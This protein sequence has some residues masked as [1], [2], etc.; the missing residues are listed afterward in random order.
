MNEID[1]AIEEFCQ[2]NGMTRE[3]LESPAGDIEITNPI[4]SLPEGLRVGGTLTL[5]AQSL[6]SVPDTIVVNNLHIIGEDADI[7]YPSFHVQNDVTLW[8]CNIV[9]TPQEMVVHGNLVMNGVQAQVEP[10]QL[11]VEGML[12]VE[13]LKTPDVPLVSTTTKV[14]NLYI[15]GNHQQMELNYPP[16]AVSGSAVV[17]GCRIL[18]YPEDVI[19]GRA[20]DLDNCNSVATPERVVVPR[21]YTTGFL[22]EG[23]LANH[24]EVGGTLSA[25]RS[26]LE[27]LPSHLKF[28]QLNIDGTP[29]MQNHPIDFQIFL[30]SQDINSERAKSMSKSVSEAYQ[31][32]GMRTVYKD[33]VTQLFFSQKSETPAALICCIDA[34]HPLRAD[35][36]RRFYDNF[37][38]LAQSTHCY[39]YRLINTN[40]FEPGC[41]VFR[42]YNLS[43]N[44]PEYLEQIKSKDY[45]YLFAH[46]EK[47]L[48]NIRT[49]LQKVSGRKVAAIQATGT[50][51]S[52]LIASCI[53]DAA[54]KKQLLVAPRTNIFDEVRQFLPSNVRLDCVTY[55]Y[56]S[57]QT[58]EQLKAMQFDRIYF[59][60][61]HH[62]GA[63]RWGEKAQQLLEANPNAQV[64]G[65]TATSEHTHSKKG[66]R[67]IG[68]QL[69]DAV[70]GRLNLPTALVNHTL[71]LPKYVCMPTS[72]EEVRNDLLARPEIKSH[73]DRKEQTLQMLADVEREHPLHEVIRQNL[74]NPNAK[75]IVFC[76]DIASIKQCK[77]ELTNLLK[78]AGLSAKSY[79]Y[80]TGKGSDESVLEKFKKETSKKGPQLIFCVDKLNEGVHVPGV[81]ALFFM[82]PTDSNIVFHQQLGRAMAAGRLQDTVVFD[83]VNN[84]YSNRVEDLGKGVQTAIAVKEEALSKTGAIYVEQ[85]GVQFKEDNILSDIYQR[86][87]SYA[88]TMN[89]EQLFYKHFDN[90]VERYADELNHISIPPTTQKAE[91]EIEWLS[92]WITRK[93]EG[94]VTKGQLDRLNA[95]TYDRTILNGLDH[96]RILK[97]AVKDYRMH[98]GLMSELTEVSRCQ[99]LKRV[100]QAIKGTLPLKDF[101]VMVA[102]AVTFHEAPGKLPE[103][104]QVARKYGIFDENQIIAKMMEL[105]E[106]SARPQKVE[107]TV[108]AKRG[109]PTLSAEQ[110]QENA[111]KRQVAK[112]EDGQSYKINGIHHEKTRVTSSEEFA[113]IKALA[114]SGLAGAVA[115]LDN[116]KKQNTSR[117]TSSSYKI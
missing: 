71:P 44:G 75:C 22:S 105:H 40:G 90:I 52:L 48:D 103:S 89:R 59:D 12:Y 62:M 58:P 106:Q 28:N 38:K 98:G 18:S 21:D 57:S 61:F 55:Q 14:N 37:E 10:N 83:M 3:Q 92:N 73:P 20:L 116:T 9:S 42:D 47:M 65:T 82:R 46:N 70:A 77:K 104:Y 16:C 25:F 115:A 41:D 99:I 107:Q 56:L 108:K 50:G 39:Q 27:V 67:D 79:I 63:D 30:T 23:K 60:E 111:F 80:H 54:G 35:E 85:N 94:M 31:D 7:S 53:K 101:A 5:N 76:P 69:F 11:T 13:D 29:Y 24:V 112:A 86:K 96:E 1:K 49:E 81:Q 113:R 6:N 100:K 34:D 109:R 2:A 45:V 74:P 4:T 66:V 8:D 93:N 15:E 43:L 114:K 84:I 51:K 68:E 102:A 97:D 95:F 26:G 88:P 91:A 19:V 110:K 36:V 32:L 72:Y 87:E 33:G 64:V 78:E 17:H 117:K